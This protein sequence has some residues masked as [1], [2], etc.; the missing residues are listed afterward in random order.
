[1]LACINKTNKTK[2][3]GNIGSGTTCSYDKTLE[4]TRNAVDQV[5]AGWLGESRLT[6][7]HIYR[8]NLAQRAGQASIILVI[9]SM[10]D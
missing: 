1:M 2:M 6:F 9:V 7:Q 8:F 5:E 10:N 3:S 4:N